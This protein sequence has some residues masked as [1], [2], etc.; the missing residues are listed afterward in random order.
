MAVRS[1]DVE[2]AGVVVFR[3]GREVLLVH[4]PKYDDW[5]FP[6]GKLDPGE[7][8]TVAAVREV[9]EETGL[10]VRLTRPLH[11]QRYQIVRGWKRVHYWTGRVVAGGPDGVTGYQRPGEIDEVAWVP[12]D[13]AL[14]L[15]TYSRDKATLRE[16]IAI[17]KPTAPLILLRHAEARAR[18]TWRGDDRRRPLLAAGHRQA[19]ALAGVLAAYGVTRVVT[20]DSARCVQTVEP[21]AELAGVPV[22][23]TALLSEEDVAD[24]A[25]AALVRD[26][27][28]GVR[29]G[30]PLV[31][32]THR[33]VLPLV[34]RALGVRNLLLRKG[35]LAVL[36]LRKGRVAGIERHLPL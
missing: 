33:P 1:R 9:E 34:F 24:G 10:R 13:K 19:E 6:K 32:C 21:Y 5:S 29:E 26:L 8:A 18:R 12:I 17:R 15:L 4:R 25:T 20:S 14:R 2:A 11:G 28:A 27:R 16:A 22:E 7:H 30:G 23:T 36:H 31:V 35:E 3:P